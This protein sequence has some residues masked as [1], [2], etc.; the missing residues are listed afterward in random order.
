MHNLTQAA[1]D[2][3]QERV[4]QVHKGCT[5]ESDDEYDAGQLARA[6][7]TYAAH[8]ASEVM[9]AQQFPNAE[10]PT[11]WPWPAA[12]F[13]PTDTRRS[14]V[15]AAALLLAEIERLDRQK[16]RERE[17]QLKQMEQPK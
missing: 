3:L 9:N 11:L 7:A 5:F 1:H 17:I 12:F 10:A 4:R 6:G 13:K 15:K 2:V 16:A 8:A 14:L